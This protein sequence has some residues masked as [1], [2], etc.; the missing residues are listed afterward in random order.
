MQ[1]CPNCRAR[2][3]EGSTCHR[4]GMELAPLLKVEQASQYYLA[5][6]IS[7]LAAQDHSIAVTHLEQAYRLNHDPLAKVL[8]D[9]CNSQGRAV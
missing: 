1:R 7:A 5:V 6:G 9:F 8:L 4:C 2:Y 3:R